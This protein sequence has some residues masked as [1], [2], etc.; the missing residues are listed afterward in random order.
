MKQFCV[1]GRTAGRDGLERTWLEDQETAVSHA[2]RL[3][4]SKPEHLR[5]GTKLFVVQ[6]V[7][8][9][10]AEPPPTRVRGLTE[11]DLS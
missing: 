9:V 1:I 5:Y 10:E 4:A 7:A 8:V 2:V 3:M 6:I 11:G